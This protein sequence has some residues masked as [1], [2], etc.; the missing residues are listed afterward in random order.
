MSNDGVSLTSRF[1]SLILEMPAQSVHRWP[2]Q[3]WGYLS[4]CWQFGIPSSF[5]SQLRAQV[6]AT[7]GEMVLHS[8][9]R[10]WKMVSTKSTRDFLLVFRCIYMPIFNCFRDITLHWSKISIFCH[11]VSSFEALPRGFHCDP[12]VWV[13][14]SKTEVP[15]LP[16]GE[17]G[18]IL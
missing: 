6:K 9:S 14:V 8:R 2:L 1:G 12:G 13:M 3:I 17:D 7:Y 18:V 4:F 11:P 10:S 15:G 16:G 5:T